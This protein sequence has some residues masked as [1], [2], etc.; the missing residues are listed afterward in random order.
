MLEAREANESPDL[1]YLDGEG[2]EHLKDV[3]ALELWRQTFKRD[4]ASFTVKLRYKYVVKIFSAL[5]FS[6]GWMDSSEAIECD[7]TEYTNEEEEKLYV[8]CHIHWK[9]CRVHMILTCTFRA[10][11][12]LYEALEVAALLAEN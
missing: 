6:L 9:S 12:D 5:F 4:M 7:T 1:S 8:S 3:P 10:R 2:D 11:L